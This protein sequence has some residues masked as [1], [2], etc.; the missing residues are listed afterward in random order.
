MARD[1][2]FQ[3]GGAWEIFLYQEIPTYL[4]ACGNV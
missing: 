3:S 1:L 2:I 4:S